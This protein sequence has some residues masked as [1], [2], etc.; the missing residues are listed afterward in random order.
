MQSDAQAVVN[1]AKS[2]FPNETSALETSVNALT[3]SAKQL[4]STPSAAAIAQVVSNVSG[5]ATAA[6]N[7]AD[8]TSSK[9]S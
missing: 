9:C 1:S 3:A 4:T 2:D 5:V 7:L 6:K 8:A